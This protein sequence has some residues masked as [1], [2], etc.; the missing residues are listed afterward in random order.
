MSI[1]YSKLLNEKPKINFENRIRYNLHK[2]LG[3]SKFNQ[4]QKENVFIVSHHSKLKELLNFESLSEEYH[5]ANCSCLKLTKVDYDSYQIKVIFGGFPDKP[6]YNY[7]TKNDKLTVTPNKKLLNILTNYKQIYIV[8]HGNGLHNKP[9]KFQWVSNTDS[10]LSIFGVLQAYLLGLILKKKIPDLSTFDVITSELMR[11][12]H[13]ALQIL[14]VLDNK[15]QDTLNKYNE[16]RTM[17]VTK[18]KKNEAEYDYKNI[19]K[20][21][22]QVNIADLCHEYKLILNLKKIPKYLK[23][24]AVELGIECRPC[25]KIQETKYCVPYSD[26]RKPIREQRALTRKCDKNYCRLLTKKE[27]ET[28]TAP[29]F[30]IPSNRTQKASNRT[31]NTSN[32]TRNT[33]NRNTSNRN[34]NTSNRNQNTSNRNTSNRNQNTSY[35][36]PSNTNLYNRN[37]VNRTFKNPV[38]NKNK[39]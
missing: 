29:L 28:T 38:Y 37:T 39:L 3:F 9:I 5:I 16:K 21:M 32:R 2:Q 24:I 22:N 11:A 1:Y 34:Q 33:S 23:N 17:I 8:R 14:S 35:R 10:V 25:N 36:S 6:K 20:F 7:L 18:H 19:M 4:N 31:R 26:T 15:Y 12:Q 27:R 13:T 30:N